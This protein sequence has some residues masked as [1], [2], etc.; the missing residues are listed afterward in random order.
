MPQ[1]VNGCA[2]GRRLAPIRELLTG[3]EGIAEALR[4]DGQPGWA[5]IVHAAPHATTPMLDLPPGTR[6]RVVIVGA[7]HG[8]LEC[9]DTLE[10]AAVDV[11]LVDR[12]N[13][14]KFQPLLYQVATAG[15]DVDDITQPIRHITR[16]QANADVRLGLVTAVDLEGRAVVLDGGERLGYDALV[17]APGAST[18][19][20]GVEGA[21]EHGFPLKNVPDAVALR[22]RVLR[23]FEAVALEDG[24][25]EGGAL[26]FVV[27]GGGPTGV[28]TAGALCELL[29]VLERDFPR[30]AVD[31]ARVVLVDGDQLPLTGYTPELRAYTKNTLVHKGTDVRFGVNVSRVTDAGVDLED[32]THIEARTVVWAAGVRANPLCDALSQAHGWEQVGGGR[33]EVDAALRVSGLE[34]V[35]VIGD[36]A[37]A[38][39]AEG[40]LFAQVAIQ[41]GRYVARRIEAATS[42]AP[43]IGPFEYDDLGQMATIGRNAAVLQTPGG[44]TLTGR[45]AWLGWLA[46]HLVSL[47]GF[48]N[49]VSVL[50]SWLY[51]YV[52]YDRGPRL[53][54]TS[55]RPAPDRPPALEAA[56]ESRGRAG[57]S[58]DRALEG[59]EGKGGEV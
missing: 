15:L 53:I 25:V 9:L 20:Y 37:G 23:Q 5:G 11:V 43:D 44:F 16:S 51:N 24:L 46:V 47:I 33:I 4:P 54:L 57:G 18:A 1:R 6:P 35:F 58:Y 30:V 49:R 10:D 13:Y 56:T 29:A 34:D 7:G 32:G 48:R 36:A 17:L 39:D 14:H 59:E 19:T 28:E 12:N 3:R 22:S 45:L 42:R 52:T 2:R 8:G 26:T 40:N 21:F 50:L 31:R 41:Q 27:V 55:E 38:R